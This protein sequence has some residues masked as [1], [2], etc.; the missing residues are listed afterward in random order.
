M[1]I[2]VLSFALITALALTGC[3]DNFKKMQEQANQQFG[4]Q[5]FKT[6]ISLVEMYKL[7]HG[8]YPISLDSLEFTGDWD[9]LALQSTEYKKL[10][11]GYELNVVNGWMGSPDSLKLQY[12]ASFWKGLGIR[13]SN[14]MDSAND[15]LRKQPTK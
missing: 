5:H 8:Y 3:Q 14:L 11:G 12:P 9:K 1:K 10:D 6:T 2:K 4:D 15:S 13:K 7:R